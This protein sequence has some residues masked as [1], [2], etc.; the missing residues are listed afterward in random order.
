MVYPI[1]DK[2]LTIQGGAGFL[3]STVRKQNR[4]EMYS[5]K[6]LLYRV[7]VM[8]DYYNTVAN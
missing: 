4:I 3:P 7:G 5:G 2:S 8:S 1:I 6:L